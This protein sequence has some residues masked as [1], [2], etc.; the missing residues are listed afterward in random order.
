MSIEDEI[1]EEFFQKL[2]KDEKFP[3]KVLN[4]LK[5]LKN[6]NNVISKD[7]ILN[8]IKEGVIDENKEH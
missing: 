6:D 4:N 1:F 5:E 2:E 7:L 3:N 8:A